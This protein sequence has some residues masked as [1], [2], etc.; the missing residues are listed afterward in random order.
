MA[1]C[2]GENTIGVNSVLG[3]PK[4]FIHFCTPFSMEDIDNG[5]EE[6]VVVMGGLLALLKSL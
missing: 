2:S 6:K 4:L 1:R 3:F 5:W